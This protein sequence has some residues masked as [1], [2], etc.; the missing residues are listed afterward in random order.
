MNKLLSFKVMIKTLFFIGVCESFSFFWGGGAYMKVFQLSVLMKKFKATITQNVVKKSFFPNNSLFSLSWSQKP[1]ILS[2]H[3]TYPR[4]MKKWAYFSPSY[5]LA[6]CP[7]TKYLTCLFFPWKC[8]TYFEYKEP[9]PKVH[10]FSF[11]RSKLYWH[12]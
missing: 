3:S 5:T 12:E 8:P 6:L 4:M 10:C 2:L 1:S 11:L 7:N 9:L